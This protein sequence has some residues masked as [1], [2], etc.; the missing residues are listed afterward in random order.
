MLLGMVLSAGFEG[1]WIFAELDVF[2]IE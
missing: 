1:R 2:L